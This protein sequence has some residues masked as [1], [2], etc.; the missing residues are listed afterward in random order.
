[1]E[2]IE[3]Y[4]NSEEEQK[5]QSKELFRRYVV[6]HF[7]H[8]EFGLRQGDKNINVEIKTEDFGQT[9]H[10]KITTDDR[11]YDSKKYLREL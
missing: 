9:E 10:V 2:P 8:T 5:G 1:M 6:G 11:C 3:Q 4:S 7:Q